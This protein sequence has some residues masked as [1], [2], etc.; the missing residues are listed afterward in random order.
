MGE[1]RE[2]LESLESKELIKD[3]AGVVLVEEE[4]TLRVFERVHL[5]LAVRRLRLKSPIRHGFR[6]K[7]LVRFLFDQI[8]FCNHTHLVRA[9]IETADLEKHEALLP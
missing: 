3:G 2:V 1:D 5:H 7:L 9:V 8:K 6:C 4:E